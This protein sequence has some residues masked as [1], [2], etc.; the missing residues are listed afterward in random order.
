MLEMDDQ[1]VANACTFWVG[2]SVLTLTAPDTY[3]VL[4]RLPSTHGTSGAPA[5]PS[6]GLTQA[7]LAAAAAS[8]AASTA[9][10]SAVRSEA[11]VVNEKMELFWQYI[12][13]MLTN[14]GQMPLARIVMMLKLV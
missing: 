7:S 10:A 2:M 11:E 9:V 14:Q 12:M 8:A 4:E 13:G 6:A 5:S 1:L 3:T